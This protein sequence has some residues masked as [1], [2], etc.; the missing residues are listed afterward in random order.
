MNV[1]KAEFLP[2]MF[3]ASLREGRASSDHSDV[4]VSSGFTLRDIV[5]KV[6][7]GKAPHRREMPW[8]RALEESTELPT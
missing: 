4:S 1:G 2:E 7:P 8:E 6:K 5:V 3:V